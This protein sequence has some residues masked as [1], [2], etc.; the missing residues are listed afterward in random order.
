MDGE[1]RILITATQG[2]SASPPVCAFEK[3]VGSNR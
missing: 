3:T 1:F 2:A